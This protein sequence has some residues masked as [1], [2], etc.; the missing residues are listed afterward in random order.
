MP[1]GVMQNQRAHKGQLKCALRLD[2]VAWVPDLINLDAQIHNDNT[3]FA[4]LIEWTSRGF[5]D[6][7][8]RGFRK[9]AILVKLQETG[10]FFITRLHQGTHV[11]VRKERVCEPLCQGTLTIRHDQ[12]VSLGSGTRKTPPVFRLLTVTSAAGDDQTPLYF[13]TNRFDL[14]PFEVAAI[15]RYRWQI[16]LFFRWLKSSLKIAHFFSSSENGVYLQLYV[17]LI[18]HLLLLHYHR[19]QGLRGHLG[20]GTQ[21]HAFHTF[22]L[23]LLGLGFRMGLWVATLHRAPSFS[24]VTSHDIVTVDLFHTFMNGHYCLAGVT[25]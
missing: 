4:S 5:T 2:G 19:Q 9:L 17:T 10:N 20:I 8:D 11:T 7:F 21:R 22:C 13:L 24:P 1:W 6:L 16:E 12:C 3:H 15:Y 23:T 25:V 18:V 14:D